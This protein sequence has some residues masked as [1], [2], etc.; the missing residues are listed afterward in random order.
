MTPRSKQI[1]R[2]S[3]HRK[4][5][6]P[7]LEQHRIAIIVCYFG[8]WPAW[9]DLYL[10]SC[11]Y[12]PSVDFLIFSDCGT[13]KTQYSNVQ[14]VDFTLE[15]FNKRAS[16][17]LG[18]SVQVR[19]PYKL[20]D[21][22]PAFGVIF[23]DYLDGYDFWGNSDLDIIY[24]DIRSFLTKELLSKYDVVSARNEYL[25][26]HLTLYRNSPKI[27]RLFETSADFPRVFEE[28]DV[29]SFSEC[30][31]MWRHLHNGGSIFDRYV[32][33]DKL[34]VRKKKPAVESMSHIVRRMQKEG[35]LRAHFKTLI[36]DRPELLG[37]AWKL[38]WE[39]GTLADAL[40]GER[41]LYFH[42]VGLKD[43]SDFTVPAWKVIPDRFF[44]TR[45]GFSSDGYMRKSISDWLVESAPLAG[46]FIRWKHLPY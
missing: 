44:I 28:H 23:S 41:A 5:P 17:K 36:K 31:R 10:K 20:C 27:S 11:Q 30:G 45:K 32:Y 15:Q 18:L 22:K 25:A 34:P 26:G 13:P 29:F 2:D 9:L 33:M 46:R 38:V 12:N 4:K 16:D 19:A 8:H 1:I 39:E 35:R 14:I 43:R 7:L 21:F 37:R 3:A 40:T 24:G 6:L 42:M